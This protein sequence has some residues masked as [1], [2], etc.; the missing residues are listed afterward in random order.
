MRTQLDSIQTQ[1]MRGLEVVNG[2]LRAQ[3]APEGSQRA[4]PNPQTA[5]ATQQ[6]PL[7]TTP[8]RSDPTI[9]VLGPTVRNGTP[10]LL[11]G[12]EADRPPASERKY[13]SLPS[14]NRNFQANLRW[15]I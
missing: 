5:A 10:V 14:F 11:T 1:L 3:T 6:T 8:P 15:E 9:P 13:A 7:T 2:E 12:T 4:I